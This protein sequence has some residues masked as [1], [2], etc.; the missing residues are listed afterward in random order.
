MPEK[1]N[2][3]KKIFEKREPLCCIVLILLYVAVNSYCL[4]NF[5]TTDHRTSIMNT[6]FSAGLIL[7]M[8]DLNRTSYYGLVGIREWKK[9]LYFLPLLLI[10]SVNLWGGVHIKN[11][12]DE[13]LFHIITMINV[14]FIEEIIFRGFLFK[15]IAK[16]NLKCAMVVSAVTF[17]VGHIVNLLNGADVIPTLLQICYATAIGFLFVVIFYKS[18]SLIPCIITHALVNS[19]SV[20]SGQN[21]TLSYISSAF[22]IVVSAIYA[23]YINRT[24]Q[25]ETK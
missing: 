12:A 19:L 15:M 2:N 22:L 1:E 6:I 10:I 25:E 21:E 9:Y 17:G 23:I 5:G 24:V 18:R 16:N 14:G 8:L 7:L 4:Q 20:F 3:V 11:T 13:I